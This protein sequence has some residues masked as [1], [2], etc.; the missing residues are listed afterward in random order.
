MNKIT[1]NFDELVGFDYTD[2]EEWRT[3]V[4][5]TVVPVYQDVQALCE[6]REWMKEIAG[7]KGIITKDDLDKN[8][9]LKTILFGGLTDD[10]EQPPDGEY[11]VCGIYRNILEFKFDPQGAKFSRSATLEFFKGEDLFGLSHSK[12]LLELSNTC[13]KIMERFGIHG[14]C[15]KYDLRQHPEKLQEFLNDFLCHLQKATINHNSKIFF[16]KGLNYAHLKGL[17]E[18]YPRLGNGTIRDQVFLLIG[19][20]PWDFPC[21]VEDD[22]RDAYTLYRHQEGGFAESVAKMNWQIWVLLDALA[23]KF[24]YLPISIGSSSRSYIAAL[25]EDGFNASITEFEDYF[26][27]RSYTSDNRKENPE[28]T[29]LIDESGFISVQG[30]YSDYIRE[31]IPQYPTIQKKKGIEEIMDKLFPAVITGLLELKCNSGTELTF[32]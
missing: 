32:Y 11:P 6:L 14:G 27:K 3:F 29:L 10:L 8:E 13:N 26:S 22:D 17:E 25:K 1:A 2:E 9:S 19:I 24:G 28:R 4:E 20:E 12:N 30:D 31:I 5:E 16:I 7:E 18:Y 23:V 21:H 15:C